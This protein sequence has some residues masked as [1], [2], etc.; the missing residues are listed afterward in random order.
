MSVLELISL[1]DVEDDGDNSIIVCYSTDDDGGIGTCDGR[2][3]IQ[4]LR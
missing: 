3:K 1:L 4:R 2:V